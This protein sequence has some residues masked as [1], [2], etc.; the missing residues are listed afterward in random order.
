MLTYYLSVVTSAFLGVVMGGFNEGGFILKLLI[1]FPVKILPA[2]SSM[3]LILYLYGKLPLG[4]YT[5]YSVNLACILIGGQVLYGWVGNSVVYFYSTLNKPAELV[6]SAVRFLLISIPVAAIFVAALCIVFSGVEIFFY[7]FS[8]FISQVLFFFFSSVCQAAMLIK[9]QLYAVLLQVAMQLLGVFYLFSI[10]SYSYIYVFAALTV[11]YLIAACYLAFAFFRRHSWPSSSLGQL[12]EHVAMLYCYGAPL[13]PW[14]VGVLM[15]GSSDRF[16]LGMFKPQHSDAYLS[17]KDLFVGAGGLISMPMLMLVHTMVMSSFNSKK[18][19]PF[20]VIEESLLYV[21]TGFYLGWIFVYFVG[22]DLLAII[23]G[24]SLD[25]SI[26]SAS[27]AYVAVFLSC[28]SIYMQKRLEAHRKLKVIACFSLVSAFIALFFAGLGCYYFGV[29]GAA[30]AF[31]VGN[32]SYFLMVC[33]WGGSG[34]VFFKAISRMVVPCII[35]FSCMSIVSYILE[36]VFKNNIYLAIGLWSGAFAMVSL[37][38]F[39]KLIRWRKFHAA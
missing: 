30:F 20:V 29:E 23:S 2:L 17:L 24:K 13:M 35:V 33:R 7:G 10:F 16:V 39:W 5:L 12:R 31:F 4:E 18:I 8:L 27:F 38:L 25:V 3:F 6:A 21:M 36:L 37:I 9:D 15:V 32:F 34:R 14:M 19:F 1:Y 11:G 28:S 22:F 26:V